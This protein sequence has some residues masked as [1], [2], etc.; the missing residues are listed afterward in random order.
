MESSCCKQYSCNNTSMLV[1]LCDPVCESVCITKCFTRCRR[2]SAGHPTVS[3]NMTAEHCCVVCN[4]AAVTSSHHYLC[5][6]TSFN[7]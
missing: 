1:Q 5:F 2:G 4:N 6:I 7:L 3:R